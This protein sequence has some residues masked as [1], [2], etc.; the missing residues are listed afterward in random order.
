MPNF[1]VPTIEGL[2][3][4]PIDL[5]H[6]QRQR[7]LPGVQHEVVVVPHEAIGEHLGIESIERL[8]YDI[9]QRLSVLVIDEDRLAAVAARGDVVDGAWE[10][11]AQ[12]AG[13]ANKLRLGE[14][15]DKA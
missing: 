8:T 5:A 6:E 3:V 13:H 4:H 14:A 10:F 1:L 15:K 7:G 12:G 9:Q 11:D 2:G